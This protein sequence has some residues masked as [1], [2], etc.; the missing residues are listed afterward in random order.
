[1]ARRCRI[2]RLVFDVA[3]G[4]SGSSPRAQWLEQIQQA[5]QVIAFAFAAVPFACTARIS[6]T[7]RRPVLLGLGHRRACCT[8]PSPL[9][10]ALM[11]HAPSRF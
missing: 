10:G 4:P 7:I 1:M 9:A 8:D 11:D 3:A 6:L 5:F 2:K